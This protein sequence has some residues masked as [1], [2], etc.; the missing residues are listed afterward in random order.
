MVNININIQKKD[1]FLISALVVFLIGTGIIIAY[2][3]GGTTNPA[4]VGHS[5]NELQKC[6]AGQ[7]L[8]SN[9]STGEW[10]CENIFN[11]RQVIG[12]NVAG[13]SYA[14]CSIN[15]FVAGG[16]A[17]CVDNIN[18]GGRVY[19]SQPFGNA[20]EAAC[21]DSSGNIRGATAFAICCK[22]N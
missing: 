9:S 3:P 18:P 2:N 21:I 12:P 20:W 8:K 1:L 17:T 6:P 19:A 7:I 15:E 16:G 14:N 13:T 5:L 10:N 4:I 11:C 22:T